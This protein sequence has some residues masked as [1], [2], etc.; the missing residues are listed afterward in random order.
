M[1]ELAVAQEDD[2]FDLL[3]RHAVEEEAGRTLEERI[4]C[5]PLPEAA[6]VAYLPAF[7]A[8][9]PLIPL[10]VRHAAYTI[11][12]FYILMPYVCHVLA[13]WTWLQY[14]LSQVLDLIFELALDL[15]V[16]GVEEFVDEGDGCSLW[17]LYMF[18]GIE[19]VNK[20][21]GDLHFGL[22]ERWPAHQ[23]PHG[24][25]EVMGDINHEL[26][27]FVTGPKGL[28]NEHIEVILGGF[29][30]EHGCCGYGSCAG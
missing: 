8:H 23:V 12:G 24:C 11:V 6:G 21:L 25:I 29:A 27:G 30:Y 7:V 4:G 19:L 28:S 14:L 13:L 9:L 1:V 3:F 16:E 10:L 17:L 2:I 5:L 15:Y 20:V 26:L 18:E 22:V